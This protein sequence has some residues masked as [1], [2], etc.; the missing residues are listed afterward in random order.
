M[1]LDIYLYRYDNFEDTQDRET[2][3][4]EYTEKLWE[5]SGDYESLSEEKKEEIREKSKEFAKSL[6]L[7][8]W[9]SDE[10]TC[11]KIE[12]PHSD[13]PEHYFRIGYFR[14]SYNS[15]GIERILT[16]LGVPTM[17]NIF[18]Y[19]G[20]YHLKPDWE[21]SLVR[22]EESINQLK[23][24]GNYRVNCITGNIFIENQIKSEKDA[25]DVFMKES[26]REH[27]PEMMSYSNK[28]GSFY[29]D[30]PLEVI[31]MV[32][33][34]TSILKEIECVYVIT[35]SSNEWY[36]QALEIVRDTIKFVLSQENKN[37]YYLHWSG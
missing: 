15:G 33:G 29:F 3:Y 20:D 36:I 22:C 2:K 17:S 18:D 23:N 28:D 13:Y 31:A 32:P 21:N 10:T 7:N 12:I 24:K 26:Q 5:D 25:L 8:G 1:G 9:G 16:N 4:N 35:R 30:N 34:K 27:H 11:E 14:S 19:N 37:Q 6:N